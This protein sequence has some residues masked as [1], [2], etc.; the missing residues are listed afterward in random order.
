MGGLGVRGGGLMVCMPGRHH[1]LGF[2]LVGLACCD[3]KQPSFV[4]MLFGGRE[5]DV[6]WSLA[7]WFGMGHM[8][9]MQGDAMDCGHVTS[10]TGWLNLSSGFEGWFNL[11][12]ENN[13]F[14][15]CS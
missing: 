5:L 11:A 1:R 15:I 9:G 12:L 6:R 3:F 8:I 7:S 2:M 13:P 10:R 14:E 4:I